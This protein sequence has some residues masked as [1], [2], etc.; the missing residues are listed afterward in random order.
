M[1]NILVVYY[2]KGG[3]TGKMAELVAEGVRKQ[4]SHQVRV[5]QAQDLDVADFVKAEGYAIGSPDYFSQNFHTNFTN[6]LPFM[7][8]GY[9]QTT[10]Y[11]Y[12]LENLSDPEEI[13]GNLAKNIKSDIKKARKRGL[14]VFSDSADPKVFWN[15]YVKTFERQGMSAP[16]S[17]EFFK[18]FDR[19]VSARNKR[20]IFLT[21]DDDAAVHAG[22]YLVWDDRYAYYLMGG[23]DPALRSSGGT[24]LGL[25]EAINFSAGV[26]DCF[27]FEGSVIRSIETYFRAF[28]G[29]QRPYFQIRKVKTGGKRVKE[30]VRK[31]G[32]LVKGRLGDKSLV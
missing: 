21:V 25:W 9:T 6:W 12:V 23:G 5:V 13:W 28:G 20:R 2:S 30:A 10:R 27:D 16:I 22:V 1:A 7:W 26:A 15:V 19:A 8:E 3:N 24:S 29:R 17:F 11:T 31:I 14:Q 4:G 18:A 32:L